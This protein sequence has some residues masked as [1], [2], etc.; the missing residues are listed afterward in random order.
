MGFAGGL[1]LN[2][3]A[4]KRVA[5][6]NITSDASGIPYYDETTFLKTIRN[7]QIG[8]RTLD[9]AMPWGAYRNMTDDDL[10]AVYAYIH[11]LKPIVHHVDNSIEPPTMCPLCGQVH[12][13]GNLNKK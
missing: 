11:Q 8:A 4:G 5:A 3:F 13:A 1:V 12:G 6:A 2:G 7:G 10:K 9:A